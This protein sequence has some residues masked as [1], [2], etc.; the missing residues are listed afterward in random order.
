MDPAALWRRNRGG[1]RVGARRARHEVQVRDG[2]CANDRDQAGW[3]H[4]RR[5][6]IAACV[7][8]EEC[9][10]EFGAKF[11]VEQHPE[12]IRAGYVLNE[13]GGFTCHLGSNRFYPVQVAEKGYVT[14]K[15]TVTDAPGHGS[16]PRSRTAITRLAEL[17]LK[18]A[19]TPM[20][21]NVT[22][23]MRSFL[24]A[25]GISPDNVPP[26]LI[27]MITNTASPTVIRAGYKDNVIPGEASMV[28]DGRI[29]PG[30][31]PESFCAE[32]R[33]IIGAEQAL[34]LVKTA[35]PIELRSRRRSS[36]R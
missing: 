3:R 16:V 11:L 22:A 15:V 24:G 27:P 4:S 33:S 29:L 23:L 21:L 8:D 14:V 17:I 13:A 36:H 25:I 18:V 9:G 12:L 26:M 35:P 5:D 10:S 7:A 28:L 6:L 30:E 31:N 1:L 19:N 34:E 32:L 2:H 20:R